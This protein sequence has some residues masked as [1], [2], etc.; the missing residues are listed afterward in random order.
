MYLLSK[1]RKFAAFCIQHHHLYHQ[2]TEWGL[3]ENF[4]SDTCA[5]KTKLSP[6]FI[7]FLG[8]NLNVE[9]V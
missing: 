9:Y 7:Q 5:Q 6:P 8:K 1:Q 3:K 4:C 2:Q